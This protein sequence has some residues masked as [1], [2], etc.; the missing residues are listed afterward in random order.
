MTYWL[1]GEVN[2]F[3]RTYPAYKVLK[4]GPKN[5]QPV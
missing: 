2:P 4:C 1:S 5:S 3:G